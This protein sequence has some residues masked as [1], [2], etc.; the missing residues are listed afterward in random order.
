MTDEFKLMRD[1][2]KGSQAQ[3]ILDSEVLQDAYTQREAD[4][5]KAWI[6]TLP[7]DSERREQLWNAIHANRK[8]RDYLTAFVNDGKL[9]AAELSRLAD[10]AERKKKWEDVK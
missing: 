6:E 4:L 3:T 1:A 2:S 8:H 10:D 7:K 5:V 9:A